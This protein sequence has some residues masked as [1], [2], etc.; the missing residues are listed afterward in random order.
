MDRFSSRED[1]RFNDTDFSAGI[2]AR[3]NGWK[4][5][6][7]PFQQNNWQQ[8]SWRAGWC[9]EDQSIAAEIHS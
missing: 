1:I 4:L 7:C 5:E 9:D 6:D 3:R 2:A 8:K